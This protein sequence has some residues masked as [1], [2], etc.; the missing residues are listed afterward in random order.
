VDTLGAGF[1]TLLCVLVDPATGHVRY[2]SAGHPHALV[3][4]AD[5]ATRWLDQGIS[6]PV[7]A[8][9]D[10][11][12]REAEDELPPG[13]ALVL[14]T[15]GLVER[16][17][18]S[19]DVGLA[20]L[21]A[22]AADSPGHASTLAGRLAHSAQEATRPDDVAVLA[23]TRHERDGDA[24]VLR[25]PAEAESLGALRGRLRRW[26]E[27][28]GAG[29][30]DVADLLL[31]VGEAASNA[32]EHPVGS[33]TPAI[34]LEAHASDGYAEISVRDHGRWNDE[35]SAEH[36]G[37]GMQIIRAIADEGDVQVDRTEQG[38]TISFRRRLEGRAP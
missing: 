23:L 35:P 5:G 29:R 11:T 34:V 14:Y 37:R 30:S 15:D 32:V 4:G 31:A 9:R 13:G 6:P 17:G 19:I 1:A 12:Y 33:E 20:R 36:R 28:R 24:L 3:V 25:L 16:R 7:G 27:A 2:A 8:A 21:A 22:K 18:Q 38:T 26:L 10:L